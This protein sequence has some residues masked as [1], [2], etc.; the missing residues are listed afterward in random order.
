MYDPAV[1]RKMGRQ[2]RPRSFPFADE[3][4]LSCAISATRKLWRALCDALKAKAIES[5]HT[6]ALELI[7]KAFGYEHWNIPSARVEA[8]EPPAS[9]ERPPWWKLS[10]ISTALRFGAA[11]FMAEHN[12]RYIAVAIP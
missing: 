6:E 1:R 5:P 3:D 2:C 12:V 8:A 10:T 9:N 11:F 7:A 4:V